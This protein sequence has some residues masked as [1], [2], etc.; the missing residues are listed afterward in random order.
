M[1]LA[2]W[3]RLWQPDVR[4]PHF[5][6][7]VN[8]WF[9]DQITE[10]GYY[11]YDPTNY[12]GPLHFYVLW[13]AQSVLGRDIAVLRLPTALVGAGC[14]WLVLSLGTWLGRRAVFW[15]GLFLALSPG[16]VYYARYAIHE[17]WMVFFLLAALRGWWLWTESGKSSGIPWMAA[18]LTGLL[19]TKE[20]H[21]LHLGSFALALP[22]LAWWERVV[23]SRGAPQPPR[24]AASLHRVAVPLFWCLFAL[25]ALYSGGGL[26]LPDLVDFFTAFAA[27]AH[28]GVEGGEGGGHT[29]AW[30]YWL[31]LMARYEWAALL[32]LAFAPLC[33]AR[34]PRPVRLL[35]I[36]GCG[37]LLA[38]SLIPYKTPWC[39]VSLLWP[40][41]LLAGVALDALWRV[42][43]AGRIAA[44]GVG[45]A[46]L[47]LSASSTRRVA[48]DRCT[49]EAEPYVY[50][51]TT[52][53]LE[54]LTDPLKELLRRDPLSR[55]LVGHV[56]IES[57][58]PIPWLLG[59]YPNIGYYTKELTA[60]SA[61]ADFLLVGH[62]L[63]EAVE[64]RLK[65]TYFTETFLLRPALEGCT[66]YLAV[67][68]FRELFPDRP[69][70]FEPLTP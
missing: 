33:M 60:D 52:H 35:S 61:D 46:L 21:L 18:G 11:D 3:V 38:Y 32:G 2:L 47:M 4:P 62:S 34:V 20:T 48:F 13:L 36:L 27:W 31:G 70:G 41:T 63:K 26:H 57:S 14:V 22:C 55:N 5:D 7:G 9:V 59:D 69:S 40:F 56:V 43:P 49:D 42:H 45:A 12:H 25:G 30:S 28:T 58:Y 17:T 51:Q 16:A 50:V 24:P 39:I 68:R 23:P 19:V 8:G 65:G 53:A 6:E 1:L 29:K 10:N 37:T 54:R 66:L 44:L 67:H 64:Q 15:G